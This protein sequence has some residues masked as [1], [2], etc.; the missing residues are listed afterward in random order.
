MRHGFIRPPLHFTPV[1]FAPYYSHLTVSER[2][3]PAPIVCALLSRFAFGAGERARRAG[4]CVEKK[5]RREWGVHT[6]QPLHLMQVP[7]APY[8]LSHGWKK[9]KQVIYQ[10]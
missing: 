4:T 7:F 5:K 8:C 10:A 6:M 9:K 2:A 3:R 1:P